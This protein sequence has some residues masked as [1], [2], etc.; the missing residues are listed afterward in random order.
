MKDYIV[1]FTTIKHVI[2]SADNEKSALEKVIKDN[3]RC[4][5]LDI[6]ERPIRIP[7]TA[8]C[9]NDSVNI[10]IDGKIYNAKI[11]YYNAH[12]NMLTLDISNA[13]KY[14]LQRIALAD[15]IEMIEKG[16]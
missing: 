15:F 2:V 4:N 9:V 13:G 10:C 3:P 16:D 6:Y 7:T 5:I 1:V 8:Y 14:K 11:V 12:G